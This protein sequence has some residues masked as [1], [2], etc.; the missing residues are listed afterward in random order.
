MRLPG[1]KRAPAAHVGTLRDVAIE[2]LTAGGYQVMAIYAVTCDLCDYARR[3]GQ[4][5]HHELHHEQ[6]GVSYPSLVEAAAAIPGIAQQIEVEG[7]S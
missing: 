1:K 5:H 3:I 6:V 2:S 4:R 7:E